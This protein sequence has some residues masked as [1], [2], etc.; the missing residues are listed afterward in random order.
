MAGFTSTLLA[1]G[2]FQLIALFTFVGTFA[3]LAI[4]YLTRTRYPDYIP[5]VREPENATRFSLKTRLAYYTECE[6]LYKEAY[7]Q[8]STEIIT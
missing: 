5:R 3:I 4:T 7:E 1:L 2:T 8:V 6:Q